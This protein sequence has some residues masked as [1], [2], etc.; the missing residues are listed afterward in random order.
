M[1]ADL[2]A[3]AEWGFGV[4]AGQGTPY[5]PNW[6]ID[7]MNHHLALCA[8]GK[9]T[10]LLIT[11][12]PR[13]LKSHC[14]SICF[15]AWVMGRNPT[16]KLMC[17]S[18]GDR[19][20]LEFAANTRALMRAQ[21]YIQ[22]FPN[23]ALADSS[24]DMLRT[25]AGGYRMA[26]SVTGAAT[27][28]GCDYLIVDDLTK[29]G[30]TSAERKKAIEA[31]QTA[32]LSRLNNKRTGVVIV[33]AQRTHIDDLP[34]FLLSQPGWTHLDLPAIT[35]KDAYIDIGQPRPFLRK[36][37]SILH[38][39]R[40]DAETL[41]K[42]RE[43]LGDAIFAA[44]YLGKRGAPQGAAFRVKWFPRYDNMYPLG[45]YDHRVFVIDTAF[46]AA[47]TSDYSVCSIYGVWGDM[48]DLLHVSRERSDYEDLT[49]R[50][51]GLMEEYKPS[52]VYIEASA[53]GHALYDSLR[54]K[55]GAGI[56]RVS[57]GGLSKEERAARVIEYLKSGKIR[58]PK[59]APWLS[60]WEN[61]VFSFP[62]SM[63]DDQ[64]DA[65]VY[66]AWRAKIGF[67]N[68]AAIEWV[69]TPPPGRLFSY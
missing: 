58:L 37:D 2:N 3:F 34:G 47:T 56:N 6:H 8:Q 22:A 67:R 33:V 11:V 52:Q 1:H 66:F 29:A 60:E 9:I 57:S 48:S 20:T 15:P 43:D 35:A 69:R 7:A 64:V 4:L 45:R 41:N 17:V 13:Y 12:P 27:G 39:A 46:T 40:E 61:E 51:G 55:Y 10:R 68:C 25:T 59:K 62:S 32:F 16:A 26:T 50:I 5:L 54:K 23:T 28:F 18:Y 63:Y 53:N 42:I 30:A 19:P 21:D 31:F 14:A 44:Q 49:K 24:T 65:L 38:A 36:R